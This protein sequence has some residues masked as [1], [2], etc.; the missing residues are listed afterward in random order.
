ML[1][2]TLPSLRLSS[3]KAHTSSLAYRLFLV[4][5]DELQCLTKVVKYLVIIRKPVSVPD[6]LFN[7]VL[8]LSFDTF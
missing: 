4:D 7:G 3:G 6:M 2:R 1:G 5:V 8:G